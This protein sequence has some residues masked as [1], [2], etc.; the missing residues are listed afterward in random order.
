MMKYYVVS[1]LKVTHARE[2]ELTYG[3]QLMLKVGSIVAVEVGS[4]TVPAIVLR[5]TPKPRFATKEIVRLVYEQPLPRQLLELQQWLS[6]Y[7]VAHPVAVW[8]TMLPS[9]LLKKRRA[10]TKELHVIKRSQETVRFT[11]EQR[12]AIDTI[13]SNARGTNLLHGVTGSGKTAIYI[14]LAKQTIAAGRSVIVL[15][16]EIALTSQL[17][18]E[19]TPHFDNVHI[20]HSTMTEAA[21]HTLWQALLETKAPQ[22]VI[23]PRSALF[24]PLQNVGLI[25]IDE[26]HEPAFKQEKAPRYSAL[27]A[28]SMLAR[29]HDARLVLGSATPNVADYYLADQTNSPIVR[30]TKPARTNTISPTITLVDMTKHHNFTRSPFLSNPLIEGLTATLAA[31]KQ[32]LIF[33]NRRGSAP[34][35]LCEECGWNASCP[36]CFIPLT[37]HADEFRLRCHI[38]NHTEKIPLSC[39]SCGHANIIHKGIG[40]KRIEEE[41]VKLFPKARILRFDGDSTSG[42]ENEYQAL[43]D[44]SID[45]IIGTQV[46]AKGLDLPHLRFVGVV[47]ADSGLSLPDYQSSERVFQLLA[48]VAGRVGRNEHESH[49]VIQSYQPTHPSVAFG[50][51]QNYVDFYEWCLAERKRAH[52]PPYTHLLRLTAVYKTEAGAVRASRQLI[53]TLRR[54]APASI[55]LIGPAPSFYERVR[56]TYRW[57]I[58]VKSPSRQALVNLLAHIPSQGWQSELDP[59][60]LL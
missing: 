44:G 47:Q 60:N 28:A 17:V 18:A 42:V 37:L 40:T 35:T 41:L 13:I 51:K 49:V 54:V 33:H 43:Y 59:M 12:K 26:C 32:A 24:M 21:R 39:P 14:E 27:R 48:Q 9:G 2:A 15:V 58:I 45:I 8:R 56:D 36:R 11:D 52:F 38:C 16:P 5:E 53:T 1:P 57:Q 25:V 6:A 19:F 46:V 34:I 23:G 7:Y 29:Y 50:I 4:T 30:L 31:G 55:E 10:H 22:V 3:S 20:T